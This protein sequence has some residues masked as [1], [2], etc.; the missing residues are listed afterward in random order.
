[1]KGLAKGLWLLLCLPRARTLKSSRDLL[2]V[3][4]VHKAGDST[5]QALFHV[6][7]QFFAQETENVRHGL[8]RAKDEGETPS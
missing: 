8:A 1:M 3:H 6:A 5:L 2:G 7:H 4:P